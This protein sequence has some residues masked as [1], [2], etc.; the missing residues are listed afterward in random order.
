[1]K[2]KHKVVVM[3][4]TEAKVVAAWDAQLK[5]FPQF[6]EQ[7]AGKAAQAA[8]LTVAEATEIRRQYLALKLELTRK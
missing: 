2:I 3:T 8:G 1:M 7:A 5:N 6:R 4:T